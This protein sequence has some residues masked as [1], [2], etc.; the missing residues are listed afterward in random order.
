MKLM[1]AGQFALAIAA[2]FA[3]AAV[4]ISVAEQPA[5]LRLDDRSLLIEWAPA[6]ERGFA[7]QAS[8]ALLGSLAGLLAWGQAGNWLWL[9]GAIV[10]AANW[11][12]TFVAIMPINRRLRAIG[13]AQAGSESR[14]L[15]ENWGRLHAL[16]S[17]LGLAAT[18]AFFFASLARV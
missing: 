18:A 5:R 3:G 12:F 16:R 13:P 7:M 14:R 2:L 8:L 1:I 6:Y 9:L 11:P 15:V 4:Y 17:A 10:L